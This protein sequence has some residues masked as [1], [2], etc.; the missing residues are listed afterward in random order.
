MR[1][2]PCGPV[3]TPTAWGWPCALP[4]TLLTLSKVCHEAS[5]TPQQPPDTDASKGEDEGITLE[6]EWGGLQLGGQGVEPYLGLLPITPAGGRPSLPGLSPH[7]LCHG[8]HQLLL[9][10]NSGY[11]P[12]APAAVKVGAAPHPQDTPTPGTCPLGIPASLCSKQFHLR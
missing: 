9:P 8:Q 5:A 2:R 10:S 4:L 11:R 12:P 3:S 6:L 1:P 7:P